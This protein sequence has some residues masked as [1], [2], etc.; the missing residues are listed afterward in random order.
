MQPSRNYFELFGLP[1]SYR[2]DPAL[3]AE[4]YRQAQKAV[5]PDRHAG[6]SAAEQRAAMQMATLVNTAHLTL[7]DSLARAIYML[8][9]RQVALQENPELPPAFLMEQIEVREE[10]EAIAE[11][12]EG[13]GPER[14]YAF[15]DRLG[16]RRKALEERFA[17]AIAAESPE[18]AEALVYE[19]Q[20]VH[21][22]AQE[23]SALEERLAEA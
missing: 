15:R 14:L 8:Q 3:L 5:H 17:H 4:R 10:L 22:L 19:L 1:L 13:A 11:G 6:G 21:K 23:A 9:L 20:F 2:V 7:K 12:A 16:R 18:E